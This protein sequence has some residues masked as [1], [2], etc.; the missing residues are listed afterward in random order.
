ME[1]HYMRLPK[2]STVLLL[3]LSFFVP[4]PGQEPAKGDSVPVATQWVLDA[5]GPTQRNSIA[6]VFLLICPATSKK[7]TSFLLSSGLVVSNEH[8]V[9]GCDATNI[10][11]Y[12]GYTPKAE[13]ITFKKIVVD[14]N[15]DLALLRPARA[16]T[17][18]LE[19][20]SDLDPKLGSAVSTW[21]FPLIYN[22]PAPLLSV[23]Y[24]AGFNAV[25]VGSRTVKHIVVNGAF[26]PG[27]SGGPVFFSNDNK[28]VGVVVW[29]QNLFSN[30]VPTVI[31]D[32]HHPSVSMSSNL[33]RT[34][35]DGSTQGISQQEAIATVL[36]EFYGMVQVM[37]GEAISVSELRAFMAE[38]KTDLK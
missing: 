18:G 11:G 15:R 23:G 12:I 35:P 4:T 10:I 22:G 6:S 38:R 33:S 1:G 14:V 28:V 36:E 30:N 32:L 26:N 5:A 19:L 8:V 31:N 3:L 2:L 29:K 25:N 21:G 9:H 16:L 13:R 20:G 17:G 34:M 37:I 27:N 24:V 7:G